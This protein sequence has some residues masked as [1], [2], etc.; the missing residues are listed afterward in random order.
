MHFNVEFPI[1][2]FIKNV[3]FHLFIWNRAIL[4]NDWKQVVDLILK[5]RPGGKK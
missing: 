5:P 2:T 4:K 1:I 3:F